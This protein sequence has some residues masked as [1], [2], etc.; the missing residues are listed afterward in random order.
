MT[1]L[2]GTV[3]DLRGWS[4]PAIG[5]YNGHPGNTRGMGCSLAGRW[6]G[7]E[8]LACGWACTAAC[9][10]PSPTPVTCG[11]SRGPDVPD[12]YMVS[13][14]LESTLKSL[15]VLAMHVLFLLSQLLDS[16]EDLVSKSYFLVGREMR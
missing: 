14:Y 10:A 16:R 9:L 1:I 12:F 15:K 7:V 6:S 13:L 8:H 5:E 4:W 3:H 11:G 2:A